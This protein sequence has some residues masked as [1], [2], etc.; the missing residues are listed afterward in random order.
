[1]SDSLSD[2][3][4]IEVRRLAFLELEDKVPY[5]DPGLYIHI[6]MV[7]GHPQ[8]VAYDLD[9]YAEIP[10][11]PKTSLVEAQPGSYEAALWEQYN[12]YRAVLTHERKRQDIREQ[13]LID[14]AHYILKN[15]IGIDDR[16]RVITPDDYQVIC[17]LAL[18]P[19][20]TERDIVAVLA[21]TFQGHLEGQ[22]FMDF[23]QETAQIGRQLFANSTMGIEVDEGASANV[24]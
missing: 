4:P 23:G 20:V 16:G 19:E 22:A 8:Q 24:G 9:D 7:E 10:E 17:H 13:Y 5:P 2:G 3:R 6:Y 18:C 14:C 21:S 12:L 11:R 15:C 1:M